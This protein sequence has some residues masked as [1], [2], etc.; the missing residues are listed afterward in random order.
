M[1]RNATADH[2]VEFSHTLDVSI[3]HPATSNSITFVSTRPRANGAASS[4]AS[5]RFA[6]GPAAETAAP[7]HLLLSRCR[8]MYTAP[9]GKPIPPSAR[10]SSGRPMLSMGWVYFSGLKDR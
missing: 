6:A 9:P 5:S 4:R 1:A 3:C 2:N 8:S 7:H 10:N